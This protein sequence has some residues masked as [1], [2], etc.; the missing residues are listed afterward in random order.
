MAFFSKSLH[1]AE[2]RYS[3]FDREILV[4]YL[5]IKHFCYFLEGR[6]FT[7][8]TDHKPLTFAISQSGYTWSP[9]QSRHLSFI[10]E[11]TTDIQHIIGKQN[12]VADT[13]FRAPVHEIG[14]T[15]TSSL[16]FAN[17]AILQDNGS[18]IKAYRTAITGLHLQDITIP[19]SNHILLCDV[20][21]H[22]L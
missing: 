10:A 18:G 14:T 15:L 7:A 11:F 21:M 1:K 6:S 19:G 16:D 3:A 5:A 22:S 17:M 4:L 9:H 2:T 20:S 12:V 13:L 8:Y